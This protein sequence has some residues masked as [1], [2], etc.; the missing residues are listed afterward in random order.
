MGI[1][2]MTGYG[3]G[4]ST[5]A[6]HTVVAEITS[7][8]HK[9]R[10]IRLALAPELQSLEAMVMKQVSAALVR[11]SVTVQMRLQAAGGKAL[12]VRINLDQERLRAMVGELQAL[13]RAA[14]LEEIMSV[15]DLL[16][17]PGMVDLCPAE[18]PR[19]E[20]AQA[21]TEAVGAAL[22][23]LCRERE[24]EGGTLAEEMI[25][26]ARTLM[27]KVEKID[28]MRDAALADCQ[29]RLRQRIEKLRMEL[30]VDEERLA[31][32]VAFVALRGDVTEELLRLRSHVEQLLEL[33]SENRSAAGRKLQFLGQELQREINTLAAKTGECRIA[34]LAMEFKIELE[35]IREQSQNLE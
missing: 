9:G 30:L 16:L 17:I 2:S 34:D 14:G 12:S 26:R 32:E 11:G 29:Q 35:R 7:L 10:D 1:S 18:L 22:E 13:A 28:S 4:C 27:E 23:E 15:R 8:N 33:L 5:V 19:T 20:L 31:R 3:Q 6:G 21:A 24:R 25:M